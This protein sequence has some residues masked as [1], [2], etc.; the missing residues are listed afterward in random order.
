MIT[1]TQ[2]KPPSRLGPYE[3]WEKR[4]TDILGLGNH[5][6]SDVGLDWTGLDWTGENSNLAY[7]P[8]NNIRKL[9]RVAQEEQLVV[10]R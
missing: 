10:N 6:D 3:R 9:S 4:G 2:S 1:S 7:S 5:S 8:I